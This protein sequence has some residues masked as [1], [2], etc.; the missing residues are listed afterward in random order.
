[1]QVELDDLLGFGEVCEMTGKSKGYIQEY[2]RRGQFPEPV[3]TLSCG[4][5]WLR[6]QIQ[7]W[8]DTPRRRGRTKKAE[9]PSSE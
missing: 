5:L 1:M 9:M 2:I 3:K 4:P 7:T 8:I 6:E